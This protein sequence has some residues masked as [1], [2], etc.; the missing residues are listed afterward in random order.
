MHKQVI[1]KLEHDPEAQGSG[2]LDFLRTS[3][4]FAEAHR[5]VI[6]KW[7]SSV[8]KGLQGPAK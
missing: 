3:Q 2:L 1:A 4:H 5:A 7:V 6:A 8:L